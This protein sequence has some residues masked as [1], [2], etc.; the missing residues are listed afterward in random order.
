MHIWMRSIK[1][2][3]YL[4][5]RN[6]WFRL[7]L[8][9]TYA[10]DAASSPFWALCITSNLTWEELGGGVVC[11]CSAY[12]MPLCV[13]VCVFL[14]HESAL[15]IIKNKTLQVHKF[16]TS[17][18]FQVCKKKKNTS[19]PQHAALQPTIDVLW[20]KCGYTADIKKKRK[21]DS[22][23]RMKWRRR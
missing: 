16:K 4:P 21:S 8:M 11:K 5:H 14:R 6:S 22:H 19:K 12:V 17:I 3:F 23:R 1:A 13:C 15:R 10:D 7:T 18:W 20:R 9:M 2:G